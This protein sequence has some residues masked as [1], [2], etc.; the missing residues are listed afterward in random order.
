MGEFCAES[1]KLPKPFPP[2]ST[3]GSGLSRPHT[4][5]VLLGPT[6]PAVHPPSSYIPGRCRGEN[7][8]VWAPGS[9]ESHHLH[10]K[11][12]VLSCSLS[13]TC[14]DPT[15]FPI[16][17]FTFH[18]QPPSP[19]PGRFPLPPPSFGNHFPFLSLSLHQS[20][21]RLG[22]GEGGDHRGV[23]TDP[24]HS[25]TASWLWQQICVQILLSS[26]PELLPLLGSFA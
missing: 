9:Q 21:S 18:E 25:L 13:V 16:R 19:A 15:S 2:G 4:P 17:H 20:W 10:L 26:V 5:P 14:C 8:R 1:R 3:A 22:R 24:L 6:E 11:Q 12:H 7:A 23:R